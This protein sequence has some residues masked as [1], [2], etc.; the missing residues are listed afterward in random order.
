VQRKL[1]QTHLGR[2]KPDGRS[3]DDRVRF[4]TSRRH[5]RRAELAKTDGLIPEAHRWNHN[6]HYFDVLLDAV[7][8]G[9]RT[10]LDVGCG[11]G[12]LVR[13]L[14]ERV[15]RVTGIDLDADQVALATSTSFEVA[16][17]VNVIQGD[18]MTHPF[19]EAFDMIVSVA[20]LHHLDTEAALRRLSDL[21]VPGGV[22]AIEG[23]ARSTT[24][25]DHVHNV[26]GTVLT[27]ILKR[28]GG[29]RF[30]NHTAPIVWPP[31][32]SFR[33]VRRLATTVLP[34]AV[35]RRHP[36]WRYTLIWQKPSP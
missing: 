11:D 36:L 29:R 14:A 21:L 25:V 4:G 8:N 1:L 7:P 35:F 10:A 23:V 15:A 22:L 17:R 9:A 16:D 19:G 31:K 3:Y 20:T 6:I 5:A 27:Q 24:P 30:Y 34:N 12:M 18:V 28:T 32:D 26:V 13:R 2:R 33:D